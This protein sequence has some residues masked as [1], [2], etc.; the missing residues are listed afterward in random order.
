M[1]GDRRAVAG[2]DAH[3]GE[4]KYK[5][6][7]GPSRTLAALRTWHGFHVHLK[8]ILYFP[9]TIASLWRFIGD[10][11]IYQPN[12]EEELLHPSSSCVCMPS[13][14]LIS[15]LT[16]TL[17]QSTQNSGFQFPL[18]ALQ[19]KEHTR[20]DKSLTHALPKSCTSFSLGSGTKPDGVVQATLLL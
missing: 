8:H 3:G 17:N 7:L 10:M 20:V 5:Q 2:S 13:S 14:S 6:G 16:F 1:H 18:A 4:V 11:C 15:T 9:P 12:S 19:N